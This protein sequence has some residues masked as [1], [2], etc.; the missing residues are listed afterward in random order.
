MMMC[1]RVKYTRQSYVAEAPC[2]ETS[3]DTCAGN[4]VLT[5][6]AA[7]GTLVETARRCEW[8]V[9]VQPGPQK[10]E[11]ERHITSMQ[12]NVSAGLALVWV[13]QHPHSARTGAHVRHTEHLRVGA[14]RRRAC[15]VHCVR[16]KSPLQ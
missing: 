10:P 14:T 4:H 12:C 1:G 3:C 8:A 15:V 7:R 9:G 11:Q 6:T 2:S 5:D 13:A 16:V